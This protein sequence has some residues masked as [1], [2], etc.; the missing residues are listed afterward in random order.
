MLLRPR[1]LPEWIAAGTGA[2]ALVAGGLLSPAQAVRA[3][4]RGNDVYFFLAGMMLLAEVARRAGL[5]EWLATH[6]A[7]AAAG[8]ATRLFVL[9]YAAC[10]VVTIVLSN[11]ATAVVLTPAV[12]AAVRRARAQPLPYLYACAFV[13]NAAS[14]VLPISNPANLVVFG[15]DLPALGS[16]LRIFA[17]PSAAAIGATFIT[18]FLY[19]R[20]VLQRDIVSGVAVR[21][22]GRDGGIAL[23]GIGATGLALLIASS[24]AAALGMTTALAACIVLGCV[25]RT[26]RRAVTET[27]AGVSWSV[28]PLVAGLFVLVAGVDRTGSLQFARHAVASLGH[29]PMWLAVFA[30]GVTSAHLQRDEQLAVGFIR[31]PHP[32][33]RAA[34]TEPR[35]RDCGRHRSRAESLGN[36]VACNRPLARCAAPRRD[37]GR[38]GRVS[39]GRSARD[40]ARAPFGTCRTVCDGPLMLTV[41][42]R[43]ISLPDGRLDVRRHN[44][45]RRLRR[46]RSS[47]SPRRRLARHHRI[48]AGE[49][50]LHTDR[51]PPVPSPL[52]QQ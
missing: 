24:R 49:S 32:C 20:R 50:A 46:R 34:C 2:L 31:G 14:F 16:W 48:C 51:N 43:A 28:L 42:S 11:D 3:L 12:A 29:E 47:R 4:A 7:R 25:A 40:A 18:L 30:A 21:P 8:S 19:A 36:R 6:A 33:E 26:N 13:A 27:L 1:G 9:V 35:E 52:L 15:R 41:R 37:L 17:L 5:F 45:Q 39:A 38:C 44:R 10:V 22:L 23:G